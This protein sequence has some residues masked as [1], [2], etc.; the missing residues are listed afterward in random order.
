M[1]ETQ[2]GLLIGLPLAL[3]AVA[4]VPGSL[5]IVIVFV[6]LCLCA[7]ALTALGAIVSRRRPAAHAAHS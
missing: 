1:S 4:A 2:I 7:I 3:F 5:L 6:P